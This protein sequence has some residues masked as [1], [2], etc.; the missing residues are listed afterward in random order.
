M[1]K[2]LVVALVALV[3]FASPTFAAELKYTMHME[4]RAQANAPNDPMSAMAG[5]MI[6]QMFPP[7]GVD[8]VIIAGDKG[9]RAEQKQDFGPTKAGSGTLIKSDGTQYVLD[10]AAKTYYKVPAVPPEMAA[11]IAQM[12]PNVTVGKRGIFE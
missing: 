10:P 2:K 8:Q 9:M 3:A 7:G 5:G 12:N 6:G 1:T 11:M 4:V